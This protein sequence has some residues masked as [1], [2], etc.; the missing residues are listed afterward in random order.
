[1]NQ[2]ATVTSTTSNVKKGGR[3]INP[4]SASSLAPQILAR[5]ASEATEETPM[6]RKS[7]VQALV[8][9]LNIK[10]S[11]ANTFYYTWHSAK[12]NG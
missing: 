4:Q 2:T 6:T 9:E 12:K 1:M 10:E 7:A 11:S 5:L 3:P 8:N